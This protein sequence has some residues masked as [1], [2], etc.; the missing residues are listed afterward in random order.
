MGLELLKSVTGRTL[1]ESHRGAEGL[2]PENSWPALHLGR[3]MGADLIEVDVQASQDEVLF[4]RHNYRLPD[5]RWCNQ[6]PWSVLKSVTIQNEPLPMLEDVLAWAR[7]AGL[8]LSLDIKTAF[9]PEGRLTQQVIRLLERTQ[10]KD[11]VLLLF[12]D[13]AEVAQVKCAYP[14]LAVRALLRG[15]LANYADYLKTLGAD[16]VSISYDIFRP[17]DI[18]QIHSI[19]VAAALGDMWNLDVHLLQTLDIDIF[20]YA[21]PAEAKVILGYQ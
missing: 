1:V 11:H 20:S 16:C 18:E 10:M 6:L 9:S 3:Q 14:E 21:N 4:L 17:S 8:C 5:G 12:F 13:H 7:D 15:R 2:A 19:G